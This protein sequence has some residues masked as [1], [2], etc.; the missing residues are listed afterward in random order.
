L[1]FRHFVYASQLSSVKENIM[2]NAVNNT[3]MAFRALVTLKGVTEDQASTALEKDVQGA[4]NLHRAPYVYKTPI[5]SQGRNDMLI[6]G[7]DSA[8]SEYVG[9]LARHGVLTQDA[10]EK[11]HAGEHV[12]YSPTI[13]TEA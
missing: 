12:L 7:D 9:I 8:V 13:N 6:S 1:R 2:I 3:R 11:L 10:R 5:V 4:T